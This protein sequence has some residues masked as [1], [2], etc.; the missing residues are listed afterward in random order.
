[1]QKRLSKLNGI[2]LT[3]S[4]VLFALLFV[5]CSASWLVQ[6][7]TSELTQP[8]EGK[9]LLIGAVIRGSVSSSFKIRRKYWPV[10]V[11]IMAEIEEN[12]SMVRKL[13]TVFTDENRY[14]VLENI[15]QGK[16]AIVGVRNNSSTTL[17]W[18]DM[19]IP[20]ERWVMKSGSV[21][22]PVQGDI[23]PWKA[24]GQVYNFGYNIW[25]NT[26]SNEME[27]YNLAELNGESFGS[28]RSYTQP[29]I[30]EYFIRKYPDSGWVPILRQLLPPG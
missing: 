14:F 2:I 11:C 3:G 4:L 7:P 5:C 23:W 15:P 10:E 24:I 12:G 25:I 26:H 30:E 16:Y 13:F 17:I 28:R 1:M 19:R 6:H 22:P 9:M 29:R 21:L 18:N 27:Y 8:Q 20:H